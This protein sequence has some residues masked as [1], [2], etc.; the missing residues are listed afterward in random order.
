LPL[1][2]YKCAKCCHLFEKIEKHSASQTKKCPKCGGK[3]PRQFA[4]PAIQFK[5]S[6]WYVTDYGSK[7][8]SAT[9]SGEGSGDGAAA[10]SGEKTG[11]KSTEKSDSKSAES[12]AP[13]E[14]GSSKK[15]KK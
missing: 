15:E 7:Q 10:K 8:T 5:G 12:K 6:G 1:F 14:K 11:D 4:A 13:A 3:A 9:P 2:E